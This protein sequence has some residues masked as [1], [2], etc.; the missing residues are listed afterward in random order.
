MVRP[1]DPEE[2]ALLSALQRYEDAIRSTQRTELNKEPRIL[3]E[4]DSV[5]ESFNE[6]E[7]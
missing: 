6:H 5:K 1:V 7:T 4:E 3:M 2:E